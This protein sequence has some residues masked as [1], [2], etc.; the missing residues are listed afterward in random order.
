[1]PRTSNPIRLAQSLLFAAACAALPQTAS[2]ADLAGNPGYVLELVLN[3][4]KSD[5]FLEFQG[6]VL[7]VEGEAAKA[8]QREYRWGGTTCSGFTPTDAQIDFLFEVLR[9]GR[10]LQIV[11]SYKTGTGG[12]RCLVSIKLRPRPGAGAPP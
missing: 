2:A 8:V 7:L 4:N 12:A 11:P 1:M 5:R 9:G 10:A 3:N 6:S